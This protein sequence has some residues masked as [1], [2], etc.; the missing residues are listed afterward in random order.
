MIF[1]IGW[2]NKDNLEKYLNDHK[3]SNLL[4]FYITEETFIRELNIYEYNFIF[5][6]LNSF[7][8]KGKFIKDGFLVYETELKLSKYYFDADSDLILGYLKNSNYLF[9]NCLIISNIIKNDEGNDLIFFLSNIFGKNNN[10]IGIDFEFLNNNAIYYKGN[11]YKSF[12]LIFES[13]ENINFLKTDEFWEDYLGPFIITDAFDGGFKNISWQNPVNFYLSNIPSLSY[14]SIEQSIKYFPL[15]V[16]SLKENYSIVKLRVDFTKSLDSFY[17]DISIFSYQY[18][19]IEKCNIHI[20]FNKIKKIKKI[21][22]FHFFVL[23]GD[24]AFIIS[25]F[26]KYNIK[27]AKNLS[28]KNFTAITS[29]LIV[30]PTS[31]TPFLTT[32][33]IL[34][35]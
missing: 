28:I 23:S 6:K 1:F 16:L 18:A 31:S 14:E 20:L 2:F 21:N 10:F 30:L 26:L 9:K 7:L 34:A 3:N 4:I 8:V 11:F 29:N 27:V 33:C 25:D 32:D 22:Y 19:F 13:E 35:I 5:I 15:K 17:N 24:L 12:F